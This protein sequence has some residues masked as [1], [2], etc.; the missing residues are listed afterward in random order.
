MLFIFG[1]FFISFFRFS[2]DL[3]PSDFN[4]LL[5]EYKSQILIPH[6]A[7]PDSYFLGPMGNPDPSEII[8]KETQRIP[9]KSGIT[10]PNRWP[11]TFKNWPF[12]PITGWRNWYRRMLEKS[13]SHWENQD[14]S[15]CLELSLAETPRNDSLLI[16]ASHFWSD[17]TNAFIFGHGIMTITLADVFMMTGLNVSLPVY[18]YKYKSKSNQRAVS[19]GCGWVKHIQNYMNAS[20]AVS[21]KE[22]K[23]FM[24]M[25]LCRFIF[26][27]KS[28]EP[29]LNHMVMAEDLAAGTQIPLGKYLL[30]SA[31]HMMHQITLQMCQGGEISC[32]NGPWWLIQMWLQL[33]MHQITPVSLFN[34]SFPSVN[35]A[36]GS[37]AKVKACQTYG[38]AAASISIDI[39]IGHLFKLFFKGFGNVL[40]FPYRENEDLT[41]PCKF[42]YEIGCSGQE[43]T[44]IFNSFIKP[45][46]LPA[47]FHHGRLVQSTYEFYYPNMV[48]RQLGC[49]QLPPKFLFSTIIKSREA[50]TEGMEAKKVFELGWELPIYEPSPFGLIDAAHPLFV[51]WWQ[52]WHAHIF[53]IA[54]HSLCKNLQPDFASDSEVIS[55]CP[56]FLVLESTSYFNIWSCTGS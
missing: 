30:G 38:E 55:L 52:E 19:S 39:D 56:S 2:P 28:N 7:N 29:T 31:Y 34:L 37:T 20:G 53:N 40:W 15:H 35:Y 13:S 21:D 26:C 27:G 45:C 18:P 9:F 49:G 12:P 6:A 43:S 23:A 17:A 25:W 50:I 4:H 8:E 11:N 44:E 16:A 42:S 41:L 54:V 5:K 46:T 51:S 1:N 32:V 48:A 24:N 47:E 36:E 33:Y 22:L 10:S 14:I 3:L